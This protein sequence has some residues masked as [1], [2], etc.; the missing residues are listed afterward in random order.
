MDLFYM[1]RN[2][3]DKGCTA[4]GAIIYFSFRPL[5]FD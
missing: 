3:E 1:P 4:P 2:D 5:L